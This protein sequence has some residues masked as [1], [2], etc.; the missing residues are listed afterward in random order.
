LPL[1]DG[2][3]RKIERRIEPEKNPGERIYPIPFI[4]FSEIHR[5][6]RSLEIFLIAA[7]LLIFSENMV[8]KRPDGSHIGRKEYISCCEMMGSYQIPDCRGAG[9]EASQK[10]YF[11]EGRER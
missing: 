4:S 3:P 8:A 7:C 11:A 2:K 5:R 1:R 10:D 9:S 6:S